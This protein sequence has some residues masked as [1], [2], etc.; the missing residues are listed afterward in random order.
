M[1]W[2]SI[3]IAADR[4]DVGPFDRFRVEVASYPGAEASSELGS[5]L[6]APPTEDIPF[7]IEE[8]PVPDAFIAEEAIEAIRIQPW[9]DANITGKGVRLAVFDVQWFGAMLVDE[10][11]GEVNTWDC[12][13]HRSCAIPMDTLRPRY[14]FEEGSHGVACAEVVRDIAPGVELNLVRV[15]GQTTLENAA[16]WAA[17]EGIDVVS[18]S[19]SFFNNSYYDG[20]GAINSAVDRMRRGGV[21]LVN[22]AGNYA[23][24]HWDA[25]FWDPDADGD[26]N[27][28]WGTSTLPVYYG[29]GDVTV[30]LSWDQF[31]SC[32]DTD[33]DAI[34]Y[35]SAGRVLG[36][37]DDVQDTEAKFCTPVERVSA[38]IPE[39]GWYYLKVLRKSGDPHLRFSVFAREGA[40]WKP[41]S[42]SVADPA[43][44]VSAWT[45][46][47]VRADGYLDNAAESFSS[48]GPTHGGV[49]KPN[50][51][52]PD[53]LSSF[54]YG[55]VGF[56]G[57]SASTPA[58]AA[59]VALVMEANPGWTAFEA[60]DW[61]EANALTER[62][63][64][65]PAD[66]ELGVGKLRL[67]LPDAQGGGC[68]RS[69]GAALLLMG[70]VLPRRRRAAL[71]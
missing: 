42:G 14:T 1:L 25:E 27:F 6:L 49:N 32:G 29:A 12:Q 33:L 26:H 23:E 71:H 64:W 53:G 58:V 68:Q 21:L 51:S 16:Q 22:S 37:A 31:R 70:L 56:Y 19:M 63:V 41:T 54:T 39:K 34:L 50:I 67:P 13:A 2:I 44:S 8:A 3:A 35:D 38:S 17:D 15:N 5:V 24:E 69:G 7:S 47:A 60:A 61:L 65:E 18:M 57:T 36:R 46:G 20:G 4:P 45:V 10:E 43:S 30:Y 28:P 48:H 9:H 11:L 55:T 62:S 40:V 59:T 52:G 66:G